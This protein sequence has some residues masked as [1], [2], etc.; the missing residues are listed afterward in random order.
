MTRLP[1]ALFAAC[2]LAA[3]TPAPVA[4]AEHYLDQF[5]DPA[6]SPRDDFFQYSVGKWLQRASDPEERARRGAC[7]TSS[8]RRPTAAAR[9]SARRPPRRRPRR[10]PPQK[11]GDFWDAAMDTRRRSPRQG[12]APLASEFARIAAVQGP[13]RASRPRS[14]TCST[15]ASGALYGLYIFQ[16]E[17]NSDRYAV[18]LYQ[19]GLG[20][21]D[22]DYYFDTDDRATMLRR[23]YVRAR[24]PACS[25]CS[26]TTRAHAAAHAA[27]VMAIETE[28]AGASRKLEDLRDPIKNYN[29]M[30]LAARGHAHAVDPLARRTSPRPRSTGVDSVIVGQPEFFQQVE[31]S[32]RTRAARR[33]EDLP[34]LA[35]RAHL[36]RR[37]GR[38]VRRRELPLL[39]H[40]PERHRRAAAALEARARRGGALPRRRARPALRRAVLLAATPRSATS[41]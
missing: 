32:L 7:G 18:H 20:L 26:A 1:L 27:T 21:P 11:I 3:A 23:E 6:V 33:L 37:G 10:E 29:A 22:R 14:R 17:K 39:R 12:L 2:L 4:D 9:R 16:D 19:G 25:S 34:A 13:R 35:P 28:L 24:R 5:I 41:S 31:T 36:R 8:R 30:A 40:D 15:S 38:H